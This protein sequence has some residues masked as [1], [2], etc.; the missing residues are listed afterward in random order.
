MIKLLDILKELVS[1]TQT[2][3]DMKDV[4]PWKD[5]GFM[6][7]LSSLDPE[8][9]QQPPK[10]IFLTHDKGKSRFTLRHKNS[11]GFHY[12]NSAAGR[13]VHLLVS[14]H[15]AKLEEANEAITIT[16]FEIKEKSERFDDPGDYPSGAGG[17]PLPSED[18]TYLEGFAEV[19][20][21]QE[22]SGKIDVENVI[23]NNI[24]EIISTEFGKEAA[25]SV[26]NGLN[27]EDLGGSTY[28]VTVFDPEPYE[29]L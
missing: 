20:I 10:T 26:R 3:L 11:Y 5:R 4:K 28:R 1:G 24:L 21:G 13:N 25:N 15:E 22:L 7:Q 2:D 6:A 8:F 14:P 17:G 29:Q 16:K 9:Q 18:M 19:R 27:V 23:S 12:I